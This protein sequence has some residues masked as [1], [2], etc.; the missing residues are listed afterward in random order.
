MNDG[1]LGRGSPGETEHGKE[2]GN[3]IVMDL[4][5]TKSRHW[6]P[7]LGGF[8]VLYLPKT[9]HH[10]PLVL[11]FC[12]P[13]SPP[14]PAPFGSREF[15]V[16]FVV[17]SASVGSVSLRLLEHQEQTVGREPEA[18]EGEECRAPED[19][20]PESISVPVHGIGTVSILSTPVG[21][22]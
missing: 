14:A 11:L 15:D 20:E 7:N 17:A 4:L 1:T 19:E 2:R 12:A 9:C 8:E 3:P 10:P 5:A 13:E 22:R 18:E 16:K 6:N 21:T